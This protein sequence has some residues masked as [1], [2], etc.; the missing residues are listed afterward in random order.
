MSRH[1]APQRGGPVPYDAWLSYH[2]RERA[3]VEA[4]ARALESLSGRVFLDRWYLKPGLP[5]P[6]RLEAALR[7]C[8]VVVVWVGAGEMG[9]WQQ[10][11]AYMALK[12]QGREPTFSGDLCAPRGP[13]R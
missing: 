8:G 5:W 1:G 4:L 12:R 7:D 6:Q 3:Q 9:S 13:S 10:R 2:S 11:E